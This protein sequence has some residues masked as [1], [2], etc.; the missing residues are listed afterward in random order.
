[1]QSSLPRTRNETAIES[2][3]IV[4][5]QDWLPKNSATYEIQ[6]HKDKEIET[7]V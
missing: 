5:M 7:A 6:D 2:K 1:M 3:R 4:T